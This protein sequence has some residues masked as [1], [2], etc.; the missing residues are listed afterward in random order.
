MSS[1]VGIQ[2]DCDMSKHISFC[3]ILFLL[4]CA[5]AEA[6]IGVKPV[7]VEISTSPGGRITGKF[8]VGN[9]F[10]QEVKVNVQLEN[11]AM[12]SG[13]DVKEWL[14]VT[15][16]EFLIE[17]GKVREVEYEVNLTTGI[18]GELIARVFFA[19]LNPG[20]RGMGIGTRFGVTVYAVAEGT[21]ILDGK[22]GNVSVRRFSK[23]EKKGIHFRSVV[24]N[25][26]NVHFRPRGR[27][28]ISDNSGGKIGE[29]EVLYGWPVFPGKKHDYIAFWEI[30]GLNKGE[31]QAQVVFNY[32][33]LFKKLNRTFSKTV[34]FEVSEQGE[35]VRKED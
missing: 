11:K 29:S 20:T 14:R 26:G 12:K 32:G 35:I 18:C 34:N 28:I 15:P 10:N 24:K 30:D 19:S 2:K 25:E 8:T 33:D 6:G 1:P 22:V 9:T 23:E 4:L 17:S 13:M 3:V 16:E 7:V 5:A 27:V 21:E 31:Y